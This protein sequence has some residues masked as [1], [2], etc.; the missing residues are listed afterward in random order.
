MLRCRRALWSPPRDGHGMTAI[1]SDTALEALAEVISR[2]PSLNDRL[3]AISPTVDIE[4]RLADALR[5]LDEDNDGVGPS[6]LIALI[7]HC[8]RREQDLYPDAPPRW[9]VVPAASPWP[10]RDAWQSAGFDVVADPAADLLRVRARA[11]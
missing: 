1:S 11:W 10:A 3:V 8:L 9:F 6:D 5:T 7:G 2:W 4:R